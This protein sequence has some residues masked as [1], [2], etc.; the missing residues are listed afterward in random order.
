MARS[1]RILVRTNTASAR[2]L[3]R[4]PH[5][6]WIVTSSC[7][8]R[9]PYRQVWTD[10]S[11]FY[12]RLEYWWASVMNGMWQEGFQMILLTV[13]WRAVVFWMTIETELD[14]MPQILECL[15]SVKLRREEL[16]CTYSIFDSALSYRPS[17]FPTLIPAG[18]VLNDGHWQPSYDP[19]TGREL[20]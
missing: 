16:Q 19:S 1:R 17:S 3:R 9:K 13:Q 12:N 8:R 7:A 14:G 6:K 11:R 15:S 20:Q 10:V 2:V 4:L 18:L 5:W